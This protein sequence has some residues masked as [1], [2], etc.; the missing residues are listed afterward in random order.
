[1]PYGKKDLQTTEYGEWL[2]KVFELYMEDSNPVPIKI[3]DDI[4]KIYLGG[5]PI[6]EGKGNNEFGILIIE[7]DG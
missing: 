2:A 3:L 1:M 7:S 6:K 4:L 5:S